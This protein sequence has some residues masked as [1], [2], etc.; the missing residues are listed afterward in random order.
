MSSLDTELEWIFNLVRKV[1]EDEQKDN[2]LL[3]LGNLTGH[4]KLYKMSKLKFDSA[5]R[6]LPK[7]TGSPT[8]DLNLFQKKM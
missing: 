3:H 7:F 1:A 5:I 8:H 2:Y 6:M 4:L